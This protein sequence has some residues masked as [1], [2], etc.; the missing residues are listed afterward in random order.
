[1]VAASNWET[2]PYSHLTLPT[3]PRFGCGPSLVPMQYVEKLLH[4]GMHLLGTSHR[5]APVKNLVESISKQ[6]SQLFHLPKD[7]LVCVGVGGATLLFDAISLNL[8]KKKVA[9]FVCGE[10]SA[11]WH[12][13]SALIPDLEV[14]EE[15]VPN[16]CGITPKYIPG[17]DLYCMTLNETSTGVQLPEFSLK[18]LKKDDALI[19]VDATSGSA[20]IPINM[21]DVDF[22]FFSAQKIFASEGGTFVAFISPKVQER[23][24]V[25][26]RYI[27]SFM[28]FDKLLENGKTFQTYNTPSISSIFFLN[29]QVT[30]MNKLGIKEIQ[31]QS[32]KKFDLLSRWVQEKSYLNFYI[33]VDHYRSRSVSTIDVDDAFD[34]IAFNTF[35]QNKKW[36]Y[37]IDSYRKLNRNQFRISHFHNISYENLERLTTLISYYIEKGSNR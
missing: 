20:A 30:L 7:Y 21:S 3:D 23:L 11:K 29:E 18:E 8:A 13:S 12:Q 25:V 2:L 32:N 1:M 22:Y 15:K 37:G 26:K 35:L 6:M 27:P 34:V 9:H 33:K 10:F 31:D 5:Q 16:G 19:C 24:K 36:V 17:V 4:T 14:I 28:T